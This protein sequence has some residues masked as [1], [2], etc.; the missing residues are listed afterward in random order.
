[1][2]MMRMRKPKLHTVK[3][4][5]VILSRLTSILTV[6][7]QFCHR[8]PL[9]PPLILLVTRVSS[10]WLWAHQKFKLSDDLT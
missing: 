7:S 1:M 5:T 9:L 4:K 6:H 8:V 2:T 3:K 10:S